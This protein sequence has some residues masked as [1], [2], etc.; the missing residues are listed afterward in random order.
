MLFEFTLS[1]SKTSSLTQ[2][3]WVRYGP[4][5]SRLDI[6]PTQLTNHSTR[7][8]SFLWNLSWL[9]RLW[10]EDR[11]SAALEWGSCV[12]SQSLYTHISEKTQRQEQSQTEL[13]VR[14]LIWYYSTDSVDMMIPVKATLTHPFRLHDFIIPNKQTKKQC[15]IIYDVH[16]NM[17]W[18]SV[19]QVA[20]W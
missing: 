7:S 13:D 16:E 11:N 4:N 6:L 8:D 2:C 12:F 14:H 3:R 9:G 5:R 19:S 15:K 20:R 18:G 17:K 1:I 10:A